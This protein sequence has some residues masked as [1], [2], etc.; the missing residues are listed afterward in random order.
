MQQPLF[1]D[2][3]VVA[4]DVAALPGYLPVPGFGVLPVNSFV[5]RSRQPVLVDTGPAVLR[6][7]FMQ[8][9]RS[10]VE[11][12]DLRWIW[13]THADADHLGNLAAVLAEAPRARVI[14]TYIGMAKMDLQGLPL[15]R[16]HLL[17]PGQRLDLGDRELVALRPAVYDAPETTALFDSKTGVYFSADSFGALMSAP[18]E[19]AADIAPDALRD[20]A[21]TWAT[22]DAPWLHNVDEQRFRR[23]LAGIR[24][25]APRAILSA[26][27]P[28]AHGMTDT[29]LAHVDAARSAAPFVG[30]DQAALEGM[31]A[32]A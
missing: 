18:A 8:G 30:P 13:L 23:A 17:N 20:G 25:L 12:R 31:M 24:D 2:P 5:I 1:F 9:L 11:P 15:D 16:V 26:H 22:L 32:A 14:T 29:L 7:P 19:T 6:E 28:P 27:L 4:P 3:R 10:L 21:V